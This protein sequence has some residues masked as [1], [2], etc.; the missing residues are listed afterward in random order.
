MKLRRL[1][2]GVRKLTLV[3]TAWPGLRTASC[4]L[5]EVEAPFESIACRISQL[6]GRSIPAKR[7]FGL[8]PG[9]QMEPCWYPL[10]RMALCSFGTMGSCRRS[11][12]KV[13]GF[14]ISAGI[15]MAARLSQSTT[16]GLP[17]NGMCRVISG[18]PFNSMATVWVS[19]GRQKAVCS[20]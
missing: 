4:W 6:K 11:C 13:D 1:L 14:W 3:S 10:E 5:S 16:L 15:L 17:R 7:R 9:R 20:L 8:L 12:S 2:T 19:T 18:P